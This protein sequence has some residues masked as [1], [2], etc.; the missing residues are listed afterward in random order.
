[1]KLC[2]APAT[3]DSRTF[4]QS[5][6]HRIVHDGPSL[7]QRLLA[8]QHNPVRALPNR[9]LADVA[10]QEVSLTGAFGRDHHASHICLTPSGSDI[11]IAAHAAAQFRVEQFYAEP[12]QQ[13]DGTYF[14]V[15]GDQ[16]RDL[17][18]VPSAGTRPGLAFDAQHP[19]ADDRCAGANLNPC[20]SEGA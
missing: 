8:A 11:E 19:P 4:S 20:A 17:D 5:L 6:A 9:H 15:L 2:G 10:H 18:I 14:S 16:G 3:R 7:Q 1:M 12:R 13:F